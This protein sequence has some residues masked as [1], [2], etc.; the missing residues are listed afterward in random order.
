MLSFLGTFA[1]PCTEA[2]VESLETPS[3]DPLLSLL[4]KFVIGFCQAGVSLGHTGFPPLY[5]FSEEKIN[6][7]KLEWFFS[8]KISNLYS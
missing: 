2:R 1:V 5:L 4:K 6:N 7:Q 8:L 3:A